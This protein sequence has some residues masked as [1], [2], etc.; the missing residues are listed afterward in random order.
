MVPHPTHTYTGGVKTYGVIG[1]ATHCP[2]SPSQ[3]SE[4]LGGAEEWLHKG[5]VLVTHGE[6]FSGMECPTVVLVI[7]DMGQSILARSNMLR[8]VARLV[9]IADIAHA[10]TEAIKKHF[11]V[12]EI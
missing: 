4:E 3:H 2:L 1:V 8:A 6:L 9:I 10:K 5:G 7:Q 12:V 11:T